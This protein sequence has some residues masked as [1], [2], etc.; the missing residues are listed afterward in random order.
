[1]QREEIKFL[2][3]INLNTLFIKY[4]PYMTIFYII[5]PCKALHCSTLPKT[6]LIGSIFS[7]EF[8]CT[9]YIS[10]SDCSKGTDLRR[11]GLEK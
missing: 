9:S 10:Y 11:T 8:P 7:V 6:K 4:I 1:M 3:G 2:A 5:I